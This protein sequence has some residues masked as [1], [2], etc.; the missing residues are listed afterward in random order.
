MPEDT[1]TL[2]KKDLRGS[3]FRYLMLTSLPDSHVASVLSS[4]VPPVA[5]IDKSKHHWVPGGFLNPREAKLG[6]CPAFLTPEIRELLTSWW[7][8]N[9]EGANTPN[10]DIVSTCSV[11][12]KRGSCPSGG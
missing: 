12:G 8:V 9:R 7:L 5:V 1:V 10:W 4:L 11:E 6:E 2:L 3:K